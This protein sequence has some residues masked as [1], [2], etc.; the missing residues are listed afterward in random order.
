[1]NT[2]E[3][4]KESLSNEYFLGS[5]WNELPDDQK[6]MLIDK[7]CHRVLI[8]RESSM[9]K[10]IDRLKQENGL[11]MIKID[12]LN[13]L[14]K[15]CEE[16]LLKSQ[17]EN[18]NLKKIISGNTFFDEKEVLLKE[19]EKLKGENKELRAE[20]K[21]NEDSFCA[22]TSN[23]TAFKFWKEKEAE[24]ESLKGK[25]DEATEELK[26]WESGERNIEQ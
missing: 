17:Q 21:Y 2:L 20:I 15:S 22:M 18:E 1:M 7:I 10:E 19:I 25:L 6:V 8:D 5:K 3:D 26:R 16:A 13:V 9:Q 24:I 4:I 12:G 23:R 11:S 14:L